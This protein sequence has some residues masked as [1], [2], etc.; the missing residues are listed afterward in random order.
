MFRKYPSL[1]NCTSIDWFLSW[2]YEA[3]KAIAQ[4]QLKD[5]TPLINEVQSKSVHSSP[6]QSQRLSVGLELIEEEGDDDENRPEILLSEQNISESSSSGISICDL[7]GISA[8]DR[9]SSIF[10]L[11]HQSL[12]QQAELYFVER[13]RRV[14]VTPSAFMR[15]FNTFTRLLSDKI[16]QI[17]NEM[18]KFSQG[19]KNLEIAK[20]TIDE[21]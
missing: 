4:A 15:I 7:D 11:M 14:Y 20:E 1:V 10:A 16:D 3:L 19:I 13:G 12:A 6:I 8:V 21:M 18:L 17:Q 2:P 5:F 9:V